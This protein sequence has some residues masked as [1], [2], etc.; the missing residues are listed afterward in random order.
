MKID[1]KFKVG[2]VGTGA[3][4]ESLLEALS[5]SGLFVNEVVIADKRQNRVEELSR[6][7]KC[8]VQQTENVAM[9]S[10]NLL[11]VVKPQ[12]T[13]DLLEIIGKN[14]S[15]NQRVI[16]FAAGKKLQISKSF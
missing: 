7:Y 5:A 6:K 8:D 16:S 11:L 15:N 2:I 1:Q 4:G 12:D 13:Y 9:T 14:I 10:E 3:M